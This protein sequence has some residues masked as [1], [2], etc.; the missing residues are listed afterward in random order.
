MKM[1]TPK[2]LNYSQFYCYPIIPS[3]PMQASLF[4]TLTTNQLQNYLINFN[5]LA[6]QN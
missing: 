2:S 4:L 1:S 6:N 3:I 5:C